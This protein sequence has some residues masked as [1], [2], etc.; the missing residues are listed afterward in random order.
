MSPPKEAQPETI[1]VI[2]RRSGGEDES[3]HGG[4]WKIAYA[5][6]MTA[7]MAFFLVMWLINAANTETKASVAS[8]FNPIKLTDNVA[9]KKGL[10]A[11]DEKANANDKATD[12]KN[13]KAS[14]KPSDAK[15]PPNAD[16]TSTTSESRLQQGADVEAASVGNDA[17]SDIARERRDDDRFDPLGHTRSSSRPSAMPERRI[18]SQPE[19]PLDDIRSHPSVLS[20]SNREPEA[21]TVATAFVSPAKASVATVDTRSDADPHPHPLAETADI[22]RR[23]SEA[24]VQRLGLSGGPGLDVVIQ[25]DTIVLSLTDTSTF[26]MFAV[27]SAE[28]NAELVALLQNLSPVLAAKSETMTLRGH[29]DG[30][31]FRTDKKNNNWRLAMAR[32]EVAYG[33]LVGFGIDD[34]RFERI[35]AHADRKL[36]V[37]HDPEAAANR[38]I[39]III[40]KGGQ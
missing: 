6:F 19:K 25:G 8:Y 29:T 40:H 17:S 31:P 2:R 23:E 11:V 37:A 14:P 39:E 3:H 16:A 35:E 38:R 10:F 33:L 28:P 26:G 4:V 22:I 13:A 5:D 21:A 34:L 1:I 30:R 7:M 24:A 32:A 9:R 27:G 36:K 18:D 15:P 12:G 20:P